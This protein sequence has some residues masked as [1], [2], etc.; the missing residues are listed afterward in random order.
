MVD[1]CLSISLFLISAFIYR[2]MKSQGVYIGILGQTIGHGTKIEANRCWREKR[3]P[4]TWPAFQDA[5]RA[6][7]FTINSSPGPHS[8]V[9]KFVNRSTFLALFEPRSSCKVQNTN[10]RF[11][12]HLKLNTK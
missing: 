5:W 4:T 10:R 8:C 6:P 3:S 1:F 7:I 9:S 2:E 12:C 11:L